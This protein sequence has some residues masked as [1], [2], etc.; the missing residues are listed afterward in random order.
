MTDE[1]A[2]TWL[3]DHRAELEAIVLTNRMVEEFVPGSTLA[4]ITL[5][6]TNTKLELRVTHGVAALE[7]FA[8]WRASR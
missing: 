2:V 8:K 5:E 7:H 4:L 1:E 6:Y 3:E